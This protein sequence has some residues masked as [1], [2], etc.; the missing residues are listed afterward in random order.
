MFLSHRACRGL[1]SVR[2]YLPSVAAKFSHV[3]IVLVKLLLNSLSVSVVL[4]KAF[5]CVNSLSS[6]NMF[7]ALI[8]YHLYD[9]ACFFVSVKDTYIFNHAFVKGT[10]DILPFFSDLCHP[11]AQRR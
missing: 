11:S 8:S 10:N 9:L 4:F 5:A 1:L 6:I 3:V 7:E 2:K